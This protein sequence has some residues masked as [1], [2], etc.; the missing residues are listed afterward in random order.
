VALFGGDIMLIDE[1]N[2]LPK[3]IQEYPMQIEERFVLG[4]RN[5]TG[6]EDNDFFSRTSMN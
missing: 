5:A 4:S 1:I 6:P 2:E 3:K